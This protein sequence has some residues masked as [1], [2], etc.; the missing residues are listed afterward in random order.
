M[1]VLLDENIPKRLQFRIQ[2][3]PGITEVRTIREMGWNGK[4]NGELLHLLTNNGFDVLVTLDKGLYE[5]QNL[6]KFSITVIL[7]RAKTNK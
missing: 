1:K 2:E 7:L 3:R 5:Q 6:T 4:T